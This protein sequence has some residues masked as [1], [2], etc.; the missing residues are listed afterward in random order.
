MNNQTMQYRV[1]YPMYDHG[2]AVT[3]IPIPTIKAAMTG[4]DIIAT[5]NNFEG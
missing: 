1:T 3:N 5:V 4:V 2:I